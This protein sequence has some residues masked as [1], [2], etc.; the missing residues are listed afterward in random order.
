MLINGFI[1]LT[2][3]GNYNFLGRQEEDVYLAITYRNIN[4]CFKIY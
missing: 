2:I 3:G 4:K 1:I